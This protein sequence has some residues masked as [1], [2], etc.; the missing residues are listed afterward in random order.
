MEKTH[1]TGTVSLLHVQGEAIIAT[2]LEASNC[3]SALPIGAHPGKGF[4]LVDICKQSEDQL[5]SW[6]AGMS[7]P[8]C[9][10]LK[11][12]LHRQQ[13]CS[14]GQGPLP[15]SEM[16]TEMARETFPLLKRFF[17]L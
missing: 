3:V 10:N 6:L 5:W 9:L 12:C 2:A 1:L 7:P 8:H 14:H 17:T 4:A 16:T 11:V 15:G 13:S